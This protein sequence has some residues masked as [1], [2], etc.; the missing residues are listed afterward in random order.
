MKKVV[1]TVAPKVNGRRP[2]R[3]FGCS[4]TLYDMPDL[5]ILYTAAVLRNAGHHVEILD[6]PDVDW[7]VYVEKLV[8]L[9][10]DYYVHHTPI[11]ATKIDIKLT[12]QLLEKLPNT[13]IV[14][15]GPHPTYVPDKFLTDERIVV[16]RGEAEF[17]I[18]DIV[19]GKQYS[20][21]KGLSYLINGKMVENETAD[22][23]PDINSL[24]LPARDLD[25]KSYA[26]PKIGGQKY[27]NVLTSRGCSY[28]CYYCVPN[29]ISWARELEWKR[30]HKGKPPVTKRSPEKVIEEIR[31]LSK[32][33]Y[34]EFSI[35]DDQFIWEK[36]RTLALLKG[37]KEL[38][39]KYG[40]LARADRLT[41]EE[42]I[43]ALADSGCQYVDIGVESFDQKVLDYIRKGMK[44]E[45]VYTAIDLLVKHGITPKVNIM[46]GTAPVE[47]RESIINTIKETKALPI[48]YCMFSIATPFPGTDFEKHVK[49]LGWMTDNGEGDN[50]YENLNPAKRSII[51]PGQLT[52]KELESLAK[53]ANREFYLRPTILVKQIRKT[54]SIKGL[55][56]G[57]KTLVNVIK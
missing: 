33:G 14:Y 41:D 42:V 44:I 20:E 23:I 40:I 4:Y 46:F 35:I 16:A 48:D 9:G 45:C 5:G 1:F 52:D 3:S 32:Q 56:Q 2:E 19:D 7:D 18:K 25:K 17:V 38:N 22:I 12:N 55:T 31:E 28:G 47:T 24:P 57:V 26:N 53:R 54:N 34:K 8:A 37:L 36:D 30:F 11:L 29:A 50:I 27:T 13:K 49:E 21:I 39:I 10:A 15:F 43:K 51:K 6:E